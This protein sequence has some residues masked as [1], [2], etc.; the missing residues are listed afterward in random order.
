[1]SIE[2]KL[3]NLTNAILLLVEK[4]GSLPAQ[5]PQPVHVVEQV[6]QVVQQVAEPIEVRQV[7]VEEFKMPEPPSF[8]PEPPAAPKAPFSDSKGLID[9]VMKAY[10]AMGA[11]K[12]QKIQGVLQDLGY[13]TISEVKEH[14]YDAIYA[15]VEALK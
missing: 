9:Y 12:G 15:R 11:E 14:S 5:I 6:E 8:V 7:I 3:E 2:N 4:L 1:M 10:A 13:S